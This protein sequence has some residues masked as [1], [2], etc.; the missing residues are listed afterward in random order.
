MQISCAVVVQSWRIISG[1]DGLVHIRIANLG[2]VAE[3]ARASIF[4]S[5]LVISATDC[6]GQWGET[7]HIPNLSKLLWIP[8]PGKLFHVNKKLLMLFI[9]FK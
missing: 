6:W 8:N 2:T 5:H 3:H 4:T 1:T 7:S 9:G